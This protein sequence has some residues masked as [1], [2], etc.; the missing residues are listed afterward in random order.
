MLEVIIDNKRRHD[1]TCLYCSWA[2]VELDPRE[3][4]GS[5][6]MFCR[7]NPPTV[8]TIMRKDIQTVKTM[9]PIVTEK[10]YCASFAIEGFEQKIIDTL[11]EKDYPKDKE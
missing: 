3:L 6:T 9:W 10:D 2:S 5:E 1:V 4:D 11:Y 7:R 8:L